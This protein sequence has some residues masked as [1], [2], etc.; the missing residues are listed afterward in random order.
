MKIPTDTETTR[1]C[2]AIASKSP[3]REACLWAG[4]TATDY[5]LWMNRG[6]AY[7]EQL[8]DPDAEAA[9]LDADEE[10]RPYLSFMQ[11]VEM[12]QAESVIACT[13]TVYAAIR[14]GDWRAAIAMLERTHPEEFGR[15][16][17]QHVGPGG[18]PIQLDVDATEARL[19][20]AIKSYDPQQYVFV[21]A[22]QVAIEPPDD[23]EIAEGEIV[24]G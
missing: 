17:L 19:A 1:L 9:V 5:H 10:E 18:G 4:I 22:E 20:Q 11:R 21:Q 13:G 23:D 8:G 3:L 2:Q 12:A 6:R 16:V 24:D 14:Q 7:A 15:K